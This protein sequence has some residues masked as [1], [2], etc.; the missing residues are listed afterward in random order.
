MKARAKA[1]MKKPAAVLATNRQPELSSMMQHI[2]LCSHRLPCQVEIC[3]RFVY[4]LLDEYNAAAIPG[5]DNLIPPTRTIT[6]LQ[7]MR[8][9]EEYAEV[10]NDAGK[11]K[12]LVSYFVSFG[13][14]NVMEGN[15]ESARIAAH[16]ACFF[17]EYIA[18]VLNNENQASI[19]IQSVKMCELF[20]ADEHTLISYLKHRIPCRCLDEI[21][22][23][24]K[25][26]KKMGL[27][28][29]EN[30]CHPDGMVERSSLLNC[31]RCRFANYC[32]REC[33]VADWPRHKKEECNGIAK[34]IW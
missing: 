15:M 7:A 31:T 30:C 10:W 20:V 6:A 23:Q 28:F 13:T 4:A 21:Y 32:S 5:G 29:N 12:L 22:K 8:E 34:E 27:C 9:K 19:S 25:S 2:H 3:A 1:E 33:Q 14:G 26:T 11:M 18:A 17:E 24:V 16:Y